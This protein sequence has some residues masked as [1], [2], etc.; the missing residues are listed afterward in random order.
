[1][2][3]IIAHAAVRQLRRRNHKIAPAAC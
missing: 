2:S 1:M 3:S